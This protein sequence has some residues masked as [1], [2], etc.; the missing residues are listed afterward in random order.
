M[1]RQLLYFM[2]KERQF[3][4]A[5]LLLVCIPLFPEYCAP[6]LAIGSLIAAA[7]DAKSRQTVLQLGTLG[8][9]VL[10]I[11]GYQLFSALY[12]Y[13]VGNTLSTAA[14]WGV[15]FCGYVSFCTVLCNRRRLHM[16]LLLIG[17]VAG[18]VGFI[19]C[20][21]YVLRD[22]LGKELPN[23][24]WLTIDE[25]F[26]KHF[27]LGVNLH[28]ADNRASAT[29]NNPNVLA[30]YLAMAVP[31]VGYYGFS[32]PRTKASLWMRGCLFLAIFGAVVSFSRGAYI[33]LLSMLLLILSLNFKRPTPFVLCL[34]AVIALVP[35]AVMSRFLSI[36]STAT[37]E[38]I[39]ERFEVW[40]IAVQTIINRPL[41]GLGAGVSNF[42][43]YL[44]NAGIGAPH[45]HNLILQ[46]LVEGGFIFL[47]LMCT[48]ATKMLQNSLE[49]T[50]RRSHGRGL[51]F[52]LIMFVISF[53]VYGMVDYPFLSPKLVGHFLMIVGVAE[54]VSH[55]YL[56]TPTVSLTS[57]PLTLWQKLLHYAQTLPPFRRKTPHA[58]HRRIKKQ[59]KNNFF[60]FPLD[61]S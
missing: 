59:E 32:R 11:I 37:D 48:L 8:K 30:E 27:P 40:D 47:F 58:G 15:M 36:G 31:L 33:S 23:Q 6:V 2:K 16:A 53:I 57:Y 12:S 46:L 45:S 44:S 7:A 61:F 22:L 51:G 26:Y 4:W 52:V 21:Q 34:V 60:N 19:A 42:W 14:M 5:V 39:T 9:L 38:A 24:V 29:F 10:L 35:E 50:N 54:A 41:F 18:V 43:D 55:L 17:I 25:W 20:A 13:H 49:L 28:M 56:A 3:F 1:R